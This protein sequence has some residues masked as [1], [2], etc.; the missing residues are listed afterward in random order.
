M[1]GKQWALKALFAPGRRAQSLK[2]PPPPP[3]PR[4][5]RPPAGRRPLGR[6]MRT[7]RSLQATSVA[8]W[9]ADN[10]PEG[11]EPSDTKEV[12]VQCSSSLIAIPVH[13]DEYVRLPEVDREATASYEFDKYTF[14]PG[15]FALIDEIPAEALNFKVRAG[16][17]RAVCGGVR[18]CGGDGW[19]SC[20]GRSMYGRLGSCALEIGG[21][22]QRPEGTQICRSRGRGHCFVAQSSHPW[23]V[24]CAAG[25][26]PPRGGGEG[27]LRRGEPPPPPPTPGT[28]PMPS[29]CRPNGKCQLQWHL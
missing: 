5:P 7:A 22:L 17:L 2:P 18:S 13:D 14:D 6:G 9:A 16:A 25:V 29:H 10:F 15:M 12:E 8:A 20:L 1:T 26:R 28:Q 24:P 21:E 3:M 4:R 11:K 27:C 23:G 19:C